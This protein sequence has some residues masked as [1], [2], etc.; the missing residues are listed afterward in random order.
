MHRGANLHEANEPGQI[1]LTAEQKWAAYNMKMA[2]L[3]AER[4]KYPVDSP[5]R[6]TAAKRHPGPVGGR[7]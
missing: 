4:D 3:F 6:E 1:K 5:E 7:G 2:D